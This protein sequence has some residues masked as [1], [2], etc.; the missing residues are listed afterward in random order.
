MTNPALDELNLIID[1]IESQVAIVDILCKQAH[2]A[3]DK[4]IEWYEQQI[5]AAEEV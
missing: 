5:A 3:V 2:S 4:A 1:K